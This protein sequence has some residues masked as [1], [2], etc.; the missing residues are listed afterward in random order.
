MI[1]PTGRVLELLN[2]FADESI[3]HR[4][5]MA[6]LFIFAFPI[7]AVATEGTALFRFGLFVSTVSANM[8]ALGFWGRWRGWDE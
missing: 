3:R 4:W 8:S 1:A 6:G 2:A 5:A 7:Y